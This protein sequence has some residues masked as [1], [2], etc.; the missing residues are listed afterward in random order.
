MSAE[1]QKILLSDENATRRLS[2]SVA[3]ILQAGDVVLLEGAI[4]T[5]KTFFARHVIQTMLGVAEVGPSRTL[6]IVQTADGRSCGIWHCDLYRLTHPDEAVELGLEDA[7][8]EAICLIEWPDRLGSLRPQDALLLSFSIAD[9]IHQ[10]A[11][12]APQEWQSRWAS[13]DV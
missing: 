9:D 6:T 10:V 3:D 1:A 2:N 4:G 12:T 7:F 8:E 5:G 13:L 11:I